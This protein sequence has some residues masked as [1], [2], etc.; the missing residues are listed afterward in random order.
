MTLRPWLFI[1]LPVAAL[2]AAYSGCSAELEEGCLTGPCGA[3]STAGVGGSVDV[4]DTGGAGGAGGGQGGNPVECEPD[5]FPSTGELPCE[6]FEVL[7]AK[8]HCCHQDPTLNSASFP[9]LTYA[10][11]H[12][13]YGSAGLQR[14]QRMLQVIQ[15]DSALKMPFQ[16]AADLTSAEKAVLDEWLE[17]CAPPATEYKNGVEGCDGSDPPPTMCDPP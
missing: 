2:A 10:D 3:A 13:P 15:D 4:P 8:C 11:T 17:A 14:W 1:A 16:T 12:E 5:T 6:V 7:Q 9:L